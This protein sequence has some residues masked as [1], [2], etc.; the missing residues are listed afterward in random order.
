MAS[1]RASLPGRTLEKPTAS[2]NWVSVMIR[3]TA[4][5]Y[6][7]P[8]DA[9]PEDVSRLIRRNIQKSFSHTAVVR[10]GCGAEPFPFAGNLLI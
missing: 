3:P 7:N 5:L 2:T 9:G 10:A 4:S 6:S 1:L 8:T